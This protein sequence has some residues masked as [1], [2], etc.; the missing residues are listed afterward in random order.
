MTEKS[1]MALTHPIMLQLAGN[2]KASSVFSAMVIQIRDDCERETIYRQD[3][4]SQLS[5]RSPGA[6]AAR[7]TAYT[8]TRNSPL[9]AVNENVVPCS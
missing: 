6:L 7:N 8:E 5:C 9:T 2:R 1:A 3:A 4:Q